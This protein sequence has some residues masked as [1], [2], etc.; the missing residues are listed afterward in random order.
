MVEDA[1]RFT[2]RATDGALDRLTAAIATEADQTLVV[3]N[4]LQSCTDRRRAS[5]AS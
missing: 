2:Q 3:F 5:I 1:A 4:P